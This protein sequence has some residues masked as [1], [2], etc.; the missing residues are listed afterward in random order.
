MSGGTRRPE[1]DQKNS[2]GLG[3]KLG[4][5]V[6][7]M[8]RSTQSGDPSSSGENNKIGISCEFPSE[9]V[10]ILDVDRPGFRFA[11]EVGI[12]IGDDEVE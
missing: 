4:E 7:V 2:F 8:E 6:Q 3:A 12:G 5:F 1:D 9:Q 11:L 10:A